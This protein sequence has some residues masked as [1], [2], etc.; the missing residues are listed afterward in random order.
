MS[1]LPTFSLFLSAAILLAISP[2]PGIFYVMTR[3]LKGG[4]AEGIFSALGTSVGGMFHV[5]AAALGISTILAASVIAFNIV[6][7]LGAAYLIFLGIK[8][9]LSRNTLPDA[10]NAK[11]MGH[12]RAFRQGITVEILNPKTAL[13]FLAFIPQFINP[14]EFI[15]IQ[16][17]FLGSISIILNTTSDIIV[18]FLAGP[19]GLRLKENPKLQTGQRYFTGAGLIGLGGYV[20]LTGGSET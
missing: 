2:G 15:F 17:L 5:L 19:I 16:F 10:T 18:A 20:A 7:Y 14:E 13:F 9:I 3:S 4:R 6:K 11:P 12:K 8:T 1:D